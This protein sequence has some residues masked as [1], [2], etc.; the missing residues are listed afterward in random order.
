MP[1]LS[2]PADKLILQ[3]IKNVRSKLKNLQLQCFKYNPIT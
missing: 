2:N 1:W 3:L